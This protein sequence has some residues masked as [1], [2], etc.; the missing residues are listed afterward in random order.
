MK[1]YEY[2]V[3]FS[4]NEEIKEKIAEIEE[5]QS[6]EYYSFE[7]KNALKYY[8]AD[9]VD[10]YGVFVK[11]CE[12]VQNAGEDIGFTDEDSVEKIEP[13]SEEVTEE[14]TAKVQTVTEIK[15]EAKKKKKLSLSG[16]YIR[17]IE[18]VVAFM[19]YLIFGVNKFVPTCICLALVAY[20]IF[21]DAINDITAKRFTDNVAVGITVVFL[22]AGAYFKICF[23]TAFVFSI[24]KIAYNE[25]VKLL[26]R[27][28]SPYFSLGEIS[29]NGQPAS[30]ESV[31]KGDTLVL[32]KEAYFE[33][34]IEEGEGELSVNGQTGFYKKGDFVPFGAKVTEVNSFIVKS[35]EGYPDS[36]IQKAIEKEKAD[37]EKTDKAGVQTKKSS[38][39]S[40][41]LFIAVIAT[42]VVLAIVLYDEFSFTSVLDWFARLSVIAVLSSP[43]CNTFSALSGHSLYY[44]VCKKNGLKGDI[45]GLITFGESVVYDENALSDEGVLYEDA[46]GILRELKDLGVKEQIC[47]S[48]EKSDTLE[49]VC[50]ELKL[51]RFINGISGEELEELIKD[52]VYVCR[53]NGEIVLKRN[54]QVILT[55]KERLREI[56]QAVRAVKSNKK[57]KKAVLILSAVIFLACSVLGV[58]L[59]LTTMSAI[60]LSF[61]LTGLIGAIN[62]TQLIK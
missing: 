2:L 60:I 16:G 7:G 15:K 55:V 17:T 23:Y 28:N 6:V 32:D 50:S 1:D 27:K 31:K 11:V 39:I 19:L 5:I 53:E 62:L 24:V 30:V 47:V 13:V 56:P 25:T 52:K 58:S 3:S 46:Y 29:V 35:K 42:S 54:G 36:K 43:L 26:K 61:V 37:M 21:Y 45:E 33:S 9:D 48:K 22:V 44:A 40:M 38:L 10:E 34:E 8:L 4:D 51:K 49:A 57:I 59:I 14:K 41:I 18:V 12:I 20:E